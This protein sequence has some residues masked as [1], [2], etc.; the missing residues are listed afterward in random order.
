MIK[1]M[2][3]RNPGW[4]IV[5]KWVRDR[6]TTLTKKLVSEECAETR[7]AIRELQQLETMIKSCFKQFK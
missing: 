7:G 6:V 2:V 5:E 1:D 4:T 3:K